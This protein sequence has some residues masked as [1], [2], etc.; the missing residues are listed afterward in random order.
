MLVT[1]V[2]PYAFGSR[3]KLRRRDLRWGAAPS[4][5]RETWP[6]AASPI[7]PARGELVYVGALETE[8]CPGALFAHRSLNGSHRCGG[9]GAD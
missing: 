6:E 7:I 3:H 9:L 8:L 5:P 4:S 2:Y 1:W